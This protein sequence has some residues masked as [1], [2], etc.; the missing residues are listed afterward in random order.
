[1]DNANQKVFVVFNPKAGKEDQGD[2]IRAA[3]ASHF[4]PPHWTS[5]IYETT[6]KEDEDV[7]AICRAACARGASLV[8]SAGGDGTLVGV[9]NGLVNSPVP[10]G[11]LPLGTGNDLARI[12]LIPLK[13]EEAMDL[14][15]SD[16]DVIEVDALKVGERHFFSNVSVGISPEVMNDTSSAEKKQL[17]RLAYIISMIKRSSIFQLQRYTLTLDGRPWS[18]RAAEVMVSNTTLLVK[19]PAVFGPPETLDDGQLEV[20]LVMAQ[21]VGD[22]MRLVWDLFRRP[23]QS[24]AKLSHLAATHTIRIEA[25]HSHLVQADGEVIGH[26]PV[27]VRLV[28]KAIHVIMPKPVPIAAAA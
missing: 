8:I 1:M 22:Y 16:H 12:L 20:Y 9:G 21:T 28:P 19:P 2:E 3:L 13:L 25:D 11:I 4:T 15:V 23:G 17:G 27:D 6:G 14:L 24:A 18:I 7:A 10:L 26:T 5:E